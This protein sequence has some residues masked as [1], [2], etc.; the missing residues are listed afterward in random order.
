VLRAFTQRYPE[1]ANG[2]LYR[3]TVDNCLVAL[4]MKTG[5]VVWTKKFADWKEGYHSTGAPIV[6]N[7]V[8]ISGMAGGESTTRGFLDGWDPETGETYTHKGQQYVTI[9]SGLGG[10]L[11]RR[12]AANRVPAGGSVWTFALMPE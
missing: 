3:V 12:A 11:A 8:L 10:T 4:D 2:K 1:D 6:A 5:R 9:A 7:G